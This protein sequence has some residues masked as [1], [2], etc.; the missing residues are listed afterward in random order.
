MALADPK[1]AKVTHVLADGT[2]LDSLE[3]Y[4]P[5]LSKEQI[6]ALSRI[7]DFLAARDALKNKE[8]KRD[9]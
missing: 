1:K 9:G 8:V 5:K 2:V 4:T 3:G 7:M 6:R